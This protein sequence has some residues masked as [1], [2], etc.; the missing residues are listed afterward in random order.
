MHFINRDN[1][2]IVNKPTPDR[3]WLIKKLEKFFNLPNI[4]NLTRYDTIYD[5][6]DIIYQKYAYSSHRF[7]LDM[8]H[9]EATSWYASRVTTGTYVV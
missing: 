2:G 4:H 6:K 5:Y 9:M 7:A 1:L 3:E 8:V